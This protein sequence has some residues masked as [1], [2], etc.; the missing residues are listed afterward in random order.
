MVDVTG[1][2]TE[3]VSRNASPPNCARD[4]PPIQIAPQ[5]PARKARPC[6]SEA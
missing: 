2:G 4:G 5:R 6:L 1:G 3:H